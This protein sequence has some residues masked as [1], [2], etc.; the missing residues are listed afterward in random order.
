[1]DNSSRSYKAESFRGSR[2]RPTCSNNLEIGTWNV[3]GL[4]LSKLATLQRY[5]H[6]RGIHILCLQETHKTKSDYYTTEE[7]YLVI[8]SGTSNGDSE[9]A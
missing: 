2:L 4:T 3:E 7:G 9:S 8:L 1:M 6:Q 5:M